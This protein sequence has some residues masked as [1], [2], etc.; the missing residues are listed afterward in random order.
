M[1]ATARAAKRALQGNAQYRGKVKS[2]INS[3]LKRVGR[4]RYGKNG[5]ESYGGWS[6]NAIDNGQRYMNCWT[7]VLFWAWH[8]GAIKTSWMQRYNDLY[9]AQIGS[10]GSKKKGNMAVVTLAEQDTVRCYLLGQLQAVQAGIVKANG[11]EIQSEPGR[12][13]FF[14]SRHTGPL[15]HVALTIGGNLCVSNW[16]LAA[17][18]EQ[19][20]KLLHDGYVH[21]ETITR[22]AQYVDPE[23]EV[24]V[25]PRPFW[26]LRT[27][28]F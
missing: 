3:A 12:T 15:A 24:K 19:D 2:V 14:K 4:Q 5:E 23:C 26:E 13:V 7:S 20:N 21:I 11:P 22:L 6:W 28:I 17:C 10:I 8:G 9:V 16:Q 27:C 25:T 18:K 1:H